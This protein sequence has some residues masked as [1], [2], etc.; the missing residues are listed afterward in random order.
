M[1]YQK[2]RVS[3]SN[4]MFDFFLYGIWPIWECTDILDPM[5]ALLGASYQYLHTITFEYICYLMPTK[6]DLHTLILLHF[7]YLVSNLHFLYPF[8][9]Y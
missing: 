5:R 1:W 3:G 8:L 9:S 2:P 4:N 6:S 7:V